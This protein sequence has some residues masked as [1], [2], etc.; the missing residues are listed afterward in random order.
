MNFL[1]AAMA[2]FFGAFLLVPFVLGIAQMFGLYTIVRER[3]C[4]VFVLFGKVELIL[5][6]PGLHLLLTR[7]GWKALIMRWL[8]RR[9]VLDMR[10]DQEYLRSQPVNSEEGAPMGIGIWYEMFISDP[11]A[12]LFKNTDPRGSL[13]ANVSNS[14]VRCLS[15]MPLDEMLT[16][17]HSMSQTVRDEVSPQSHEWGYKLGSIYIRKVHF[18]DIG[19][20]KQIESKVVN[21]LRQVTAAIKQDGA[22]RV[23]IIASTAERQ[24]AVEFAKAAAIRP[25]IVGAA[26]QKISRDPEVSATLFEILETQK[27]I[28]GEARITL[29]PGGGA[30]LGELLAAGAERRSEPKPPPAGPMR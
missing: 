19:M 4:Q 8:G 14:T 10:L 16:S 22:N 24:A 27:I 6:E 7:L 23:S 18:R 13:A 17:R 25:Q 11:V 5:A 30:V 12:Y 28:E 15:N 1:V 26:F 20:I 21:R 29:L 3:Q 2:A 9:Y